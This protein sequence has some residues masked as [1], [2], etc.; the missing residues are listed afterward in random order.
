MAVS[1]LP[2]AIQFSSSASPIAQEIVAWRISR[3]V[4]QFA[5]HGLVVPGKF[6]R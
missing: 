5:V 6:G 4:A 1:E 2:L 3:H